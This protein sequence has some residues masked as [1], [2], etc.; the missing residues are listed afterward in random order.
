MKMALRRLGGRAPG[1]SESREG[2][3]YPREE[4]EAIKRIRRRLLSSIRAEALIDI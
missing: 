2:V 3:P 4:E 1:L